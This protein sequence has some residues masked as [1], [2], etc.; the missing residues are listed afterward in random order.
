MASLMDPLDDDQAALLDIVWTV[1]RMYG[2]FP[3]FFY[4]DYM[5][6]EQER[7]VRKT[8][9]SFPAIGQ[10]MVTYGYRAVHWMSIGT[11]P[12]PD[13]PVQLTAAGLYHVNQRYEPKD[14]MDADLLVHGLLAFMSEI[15]TRQQKIIYNPFEQPDVEVDLRKVKVLSSRD[16]DFFRR[17]ELIAQYEWPGLGFTG[18]NSTG[19]RGQLHQ[20]DFA[21]LDDY[22]AAA[23][24]A[25]TPPQAPP[26]AV[27]I[28]EPRALLRA[29]NHLDVTSE[30]VLRRA[31]VTR[32]SME[33]SAALALDVDDQDGYQNGLAV[34]GDLLRD[35]NV[36]GSNPG[37]GHNRLPTYLADKLPKVDQAAVDKAVSLLDKV[38]VLRNNAVHPKPS[39]DA[40]DAHHALGVTWPV[41]DYAA[42]WDSVRGSAEKAVNTLQEAIQNARP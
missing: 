13:E 35:F 25:L 5:M 12:N 10:H 40:L 4:V 26:S 16:D 27:T 29:L 18:H 38:R 1:F 14:R 20:A 17:M 39:P 28:S 3:H 30:L 15:T 9:L 21:R 22:L 33:R 2:R 34:L 42:A 11:T 8:L 23:T 7:D 19:R 31:L 41:R 36:P 24:E 32:P 37:Q 6:R